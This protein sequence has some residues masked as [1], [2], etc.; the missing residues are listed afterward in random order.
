LPPLPKLPTMDRVIKPYSAS[1]MQKVSSMLKKRRS[2]EGGDEDAD[3]QCAWENSLKDTQEIIVI[4]DYDNDVDDYDP[5]KPEYDDEDED[6]PANYDPDQHHYEYDERQRDED[7]DRYQQ[8]KMYWQNK[9]V[10]SDVSWDAILHMPDGTRQLYACSPYGNQAADVLGQICVLKGWNSLDYRL[11]EHGLPVVADI[12][13]GAQSYDI[14][15]AW[16]ADS[17]GKK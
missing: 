4:P 11:L 10:S 5:D 8:S 12:I 9:P 2:Q 1:N 17:S 6:D 15:R 3:F 16:S 7:D 13:H 14:T